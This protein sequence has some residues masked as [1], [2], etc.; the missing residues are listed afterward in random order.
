MNVK[1]YSFKKLYYL[2][3]NA[4]DINFLRE[5]IENINWSG[6]SQNENAIELILEY[7][8]KI[9]WYALSRNKNAIKILEENQDKINYSN[10][11]VNPSIFIY[12]YEKMKKD[13]EEFEEEL[14]KEVMKPLRIMKMMEKYGEDYLEI[15][16]D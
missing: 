6:L 16:Y 12:N 3:K 10:L 7:P 4:N 9:N 13:N 11:S 5:N 1:L 15:L 8:E 14:I 2:S